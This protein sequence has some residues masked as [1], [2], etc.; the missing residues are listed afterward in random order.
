[1]KPLP[2][3][4]QRLLE[5]AEGWLGLGD[6]LAANEELD[7]ITPQLRAHPAV[8]EVRYQVYAK[9][10]N[11]NGAAEIAGT[12]VKLLPQSLAAWI[13]WAYATRRKTWGGIPEAKKILLEAEPKF[14]KACLIRYNLACYDC[15]LGNLK[16]AEVWLE[17]AIDLA[18]KSDIRLRALKDP[19]LE[20]LWSRIGEI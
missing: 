10:K 9:A 1:M 20:A 19:N 18:G 4:D 7:N 8:L 16:E 5:A 15:Q 11:W 2:L 3:E 12:L 13:N 17:K 6:H 14:P